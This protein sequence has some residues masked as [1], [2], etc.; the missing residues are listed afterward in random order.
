MIQIEVE[1]WILLKADEH[2]FQLTEVNLGLFW[3]R[4]KGGDLASIILQYIYKT[5]SYMMTMCLYGMGSKILQTRLLI[6]SFVLFMDVF[7][8]QL[9]IMTI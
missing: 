6:S 1:F 5:Y 4:E 9:V 3:G 2:Y 8:A 7:K